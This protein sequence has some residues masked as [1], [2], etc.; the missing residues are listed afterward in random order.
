MFLLVYTYEYKKQ[1]FCLLFI[2]LKDL[3]PRLKIVIPKVLHDFPC[4]VFFQCND[5]RKRHAVKRIVL[6][7]RINCH[8]SENKPFSDAQRL[9][10]R[11][12]ANPVSRKAGQSPS[13]YV[14]AF[15]P[16]SPLPQSGG[17]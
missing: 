10:K 15:S 3:K 17:L 2:W 16:A 9:V 12:V 8:V 1:A 5:I 4:T 7:H 14:Y 11:I 13:L 6:Y